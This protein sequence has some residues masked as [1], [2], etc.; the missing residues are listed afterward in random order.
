MGLY[1]YGITLV[2][3]LLFIVQNRLIMK[4]NIKYMPTYTKGKHG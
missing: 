4:R 2:F 1:I 3:K